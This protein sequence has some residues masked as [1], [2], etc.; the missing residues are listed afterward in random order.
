MRT[1]NDILKRKS[2]RK[3]KLKNSLNSI[4][5][6]LIKIGA[7]KIIIFGSYA[8]EDIDINSD[9]DLLIVMP[10]TKTGKEWIKY[11]YDIIDSNI[12]TD[13]IAYNR[14]EF[15]EKLITN[16]FLSHIKNTGTII[17]EKAL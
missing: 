7:E 16:S 6:Q 8:K 17:Y 1:L 14:N 15:Q 3:E 11:I 10:S 9:L 4:K 5:N 2:E 13:I 12:A